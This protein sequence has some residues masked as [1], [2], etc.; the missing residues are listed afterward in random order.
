MNPNQKRT[1]ASLRELLFEMIE[2]VQAGTVDA[3]KARTIAQ[4]SMT[5]LKSVEVELQFRAQALR[6]DFQGKQIGTLELTSL[7]QPENPI[8]KAGPRFIAG[9]SASGGY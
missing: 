7:P 8:T 4:L 5:I 9:K 6:G 1:S 2:G 3:K